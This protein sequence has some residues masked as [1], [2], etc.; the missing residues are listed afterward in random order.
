MAST[1]S[2][3]LKLEI[4]TTGEKA[5]SWGDITNKN[6]KQL[7]AAASG[8]LTIST[9]GGNTDLPL[10]Q[11]EV[12]NGKHL[13]FKL[14]GTLSSNATITM[15]TGSQRVIIVE[16]STTRLQ[17]ISPYDTFTVTVRTGT[18]DA[19]V[20]LP[21]NSVNLLY[22]DGTN[23]SLGLQTKGY[24]TPFFENKTVTTYTAVAGDQIL[25]DNTVNG[26]QATTITLPGTPNI[27][28]EI[29]FIDSGNNF[30]TQNLTLS[31][32]AK[33]L[34]AD[35]NLTVSTQGAAFTMVYVNAT[36]GW[37]YKNKPV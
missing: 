30:N 34:G 4:I 2:D 9:T 3:D 31:S 25:V 13:Y 15:P 22:S 35:T 37:A 27:G 32:S 28:D 36:R 19:G 21:S 29:T 16:D 6:L 17:A 23:M 14:T 10:T 11:G 24:I 18:S 1:Y 26:N 12:S 5:G 8:L 7:E 33:I 20:A